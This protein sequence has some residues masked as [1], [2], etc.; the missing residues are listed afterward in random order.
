VEGETP[1]A[2]SDTRLLLASRRHIDRS[3][4][5]KEQAN[6]CGDYALQKM[7]GESPF[8]FGADKSN[9]PCLPSTV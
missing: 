1:A 8:L 2:L 5:E 7:A 4:A 3:L 9:A 6:C